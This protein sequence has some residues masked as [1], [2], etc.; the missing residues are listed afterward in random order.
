LYFDIADFG[1]TGGCEKYL[2]SE[3]NGFL[4]EAFGNEGRIDNG[5][6]IIRS[7]D[8][9]NGKWIVDNGQFKTFRQI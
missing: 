3:D 8:M 4:D 1:G 9:N 6:W 5:E 7:S 2:L